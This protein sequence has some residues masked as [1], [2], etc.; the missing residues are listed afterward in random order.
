VQPVHFLTIPL[1]NKLINQITLKRTR[2]KMYYERRHF[3]EKVR[4]SELREGMR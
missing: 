2:N 4:V 1:C 3:I